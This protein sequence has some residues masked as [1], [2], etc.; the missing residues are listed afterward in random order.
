MNIRS[1]KPNPLPS[2]SEHT[3]FDPAEMTTTQKVR[4]SEVLFRPLQITGKIATDQM[5]R[6]PKTSSNGS[7]YIMCAYVHDTNGILTRCLKSRSDNDLTTAFA[8]IHSFL[9][10]HG[11]TPHVSFLD[12]EC[13]PSLAAFMTKHKIAY[14][15]VAPHDHRSNPA[16]KA[17]GTWKDHFIAGLSSVNP[18]FP[19]HIWDRLVDQATTTLNLL[20]PSNR[21]PRLSAEVHMNGAFDFNKSPMAPPR[22]QSPCP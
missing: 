7:K 2:T 22:H 5:G 8:S 20:R 19:L 4:K 18:N 9:V 13:P 3:V 15:L 21:N 6:F 11:L 17:I 16:E 14:Q 1:T 12:N 10:E